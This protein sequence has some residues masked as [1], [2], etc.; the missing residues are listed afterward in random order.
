MSANR[1]HLSLVYPNPIKSKL[2]KGCVLYPNMKTTLHCLHIFVPGKYVSFLCFFLGFLCNTLVS[3]AQTVT[4]GKSYVNITRPNGGTFLPGDVIEVRATIAVSGGTSATGSRI[5]YIRYNDT[6][7]LA[8]FTYVTGS[9]KMLSNEGRTQYSYTDGADTDSAH[10]DLAS[11]RLRFNIGNG[12][13]AANVNT[14]GIANTN[15]GRLWGALRPTFYNGTCIRMYVYRVTIRNTPSI[16]D[17]DTTVIISAGNFRYRVGS[18]STDQL[19][20]FSRYF[21]KM[22]PDFGLCTNSVGTNAIVGESGGTFGSG[23]AQN[24]AG[25]TTFVPAPYTFQTFSNNTPNDNF[26]GLANNTSSDNTN[27]PNVP[28]SSG[29]GSA[30]R[31]FSVWDIIGDHTGAANQ[32]AGNPPSGTGYAVIINASYQTNRAFEQTINNLCEETYYEFSAWFRNICR[33][34][35]CDSAGR[36]A[37]QSGY[38]PAPGNDSSGVRPNLTFKVDDEDYYTTGNIPYD[39]QW[40]KKGFVFKTRKNQTSM[41]L[42]IRNNAPGGGG[43]DWAI[44]DIRM[45]TCLPNMQYSPSLDPNV[46]AGNALT[47]YDTVRSFFNNYTYHQW[48]QSNDG[49]ITWTNIGAVRDSVPYWNASLSSWEYV[50]SYTTPVTALTDDGKRFRLIVATSDSNL[51]LVNCRTTDNLNSVTLNVIDCGEVLSTDL[52]SFTGRIL[53]NKAILNWTTTGDNEPLFF[54]IEKSFNGTS[55]ATIATIN[56]YNRSGENNYSFTDPDDI[57]TGVYYR[58]RMRTADNRASFSRI[59]RLSAGDKSFS[60]VSVIN[61]FN[62]ALQ[63]DISSGKAGMAKA[64]L[65]DQF[66]NPVKSKSLD[67][68]EGI[69]QFSFENT[70]T[71]AAAMYILKVQMGE[72]IIYKKVLKQNY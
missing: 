65:I 45:A 70:N 22:A 42:T 2:I 66:G 16:V 40:V 60:F 37:S 44:D 1:F 35:A 49:G 12:A 13:G 9:L 29:A 30:S 7:N 17:L 24:R 51:T 5:N 25:G 26:Y 47:L 61:P 15:A 68:H 57:N 19:S 31:V 72:M 18:S 43:N 64:E 39:G 3:T 21:V 59:V 52:I 11:G 69:T 36:G 38:T 28:Y 56:G 4:T 20:G 58:I 71:L 32:A 27:N 50:T 23:T 53:N 14:Q 62:N 67:I 34:C 46:C 54:D 8:K 33:R 41:T 10:I 63:F 55:F 6:I 48:Q